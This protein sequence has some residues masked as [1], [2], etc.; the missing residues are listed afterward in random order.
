MGFASLVSTG[1]PKVIG[2]LFEILN[3]WQDVSRE[4]DEALEQSA[5]EGSK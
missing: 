5:I 1:R 2:Q 4:I 3:V